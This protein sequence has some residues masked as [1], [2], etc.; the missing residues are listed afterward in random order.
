MYTGNESDERTST[1]R[2]D[3]FVFLVFIVIYVLLVFIVHYIWGPYSPEPFSPLNETPVW[4]SSYDLYFLFP[5]LSILAMIPFTGKFLRRIVFPTA[6]IIPIYL[7][8]YSYLQ[9]Y[10]LSYLPFLDRH[11]INS[12]MILPY[13]LVF[14]IPTIPLIGTLVVAYYA[15]NTSLGRIRFGRGY[16]L[17]ALTVSVAM[18]ALEMTLRFVENSSPLTNISDV[19]YLIQAGGSFV[20]KGINPYSVPLPPWGTLTSLR[21]APLA[22]AFVAPLSF[23][24][25][26]LAV[27][28]NTILFSLFLAFGLFKLTKFIAP[29]YAMISTVTF[30]VV[31]MT[32][33]EIMA[34]Y[35][36]DI[37]GAAFV[38]WSLYLF[39]SNR[40]LFAT[41][42]ALIGTGV[43]IVPAALIIP[44]IFYSHGKSRI[45]IFLVFFVP[46]IL[47][48][49]A[50]YKFDGFSLYSAYLNFLGLFGFYYGFILPPTISLILGL[51]PALALTIWFI[52]SSSMISGPFELIKNTAVFYLLLPFMFGDFFAFYFVWQYVLIIP[53][54]LTSNKASHPL[55]YQVAVTAKLENTR[56]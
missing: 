55:F 37:L 29:E 7:V 33:F 25:V 18:T 38:V 45:Q 23:L 6:T 49:L 15:S 34:S 35:V 44:Y 56:S 28:L 43:L 39:V 54:V 19:G 16:F 36:N 1:W 22:F 48:V 9:N 3:G 40:R 50:L 17:F 52:Y 11:V 46:L 27:H 51:I 2:G 4:A 21:N 42:F 30:F 41:L 14:M 24:P 20:L 32:G 12:S 26:I 5:V 10:T 13:F 8:C 53:A 31:P 47:A